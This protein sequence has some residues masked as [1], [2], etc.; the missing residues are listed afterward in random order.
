MRERKLGAMMTT[1]RV[2]ALGALLLYP[3][4]GDA[5]TCHDVVEKAVAESGFNGVALVARGRTIDNLQAVGTADAAR[6]VPMTATTRFEVGSLSKWVAA[7]VVM[8]L[9]DG[10]VL[11]LDQPVSS[12]LQEY[13]KDTGARLTLRRLMSH[14]S[15]L[16]NDIQAARQA[17]PST[18]GIELDQAESVRRYASGTLLFEPGT[19][20]DYSQS[21][22]LLVKAVVERVTA[23]PYAEWVRRSLVR[24]LRLEHSGVFHGDS[25][26]VDGMAWGYAALTPAPQPKPNPIPD[27]MAMAGGFYTTAHDLLVLMDAVL[28]GDCL[29]P[30]SRRTLLTV[31][32][33]DQHYAM[34][35]RVRRE[36]IA[37]TEREVAWED[38]AN[39]GFRMIAR[40]VLADGRTVIVLTNASFDYEALGQL[41]TNLMEASYREHPPRR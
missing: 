25:R 41:G 24:P 6:G 2:L 33:P 35:G 20:W 27:F 39:G 29:T 14:S 37:G 23:T 10:G 36:R 1:V 8:K 5:Q 34:G 16:P 18:R 40:R 15:G 28:D 13:R 9:V 22:W 26:A 31:V 4:P 7:I 17:D 12:Y 38:G 3:R 32:M 19:A 30:A 11:N 21:N